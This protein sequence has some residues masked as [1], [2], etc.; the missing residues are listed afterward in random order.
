MPVQPAPQDPWT[1]LEVAKLCVQA[2]T[3]ILVAIFGLWIARRTKRLDQK[4]WTSRRVIERR[5]EIY[6]EIAPILNDFLVYFTF[7]GHW[8][9]LTPSELVAAKRKLDRIVYTTSAFFSDKFMPAYQSFIASCFETYTGWG[10]DT[11]LRCDPMRHEEAAKENWDNQWDELFSP[12]EER[13]TD[14]EVK[15]QYSS[16]MNVLAN[17]LQLGL[18]PSKS[19]TGK[20]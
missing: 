18:T 2:L 4:E 8:K 16:L 3:P 12:E 6:D 20:D 1:T 14:D 7:V 19:I 17:E 9:E 10:F 11:R 5:V 13:T 15:G